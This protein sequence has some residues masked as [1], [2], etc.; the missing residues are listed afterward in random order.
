MKI[1]AEEKIERENA[2]NRLRDFLDASAHRGDQ[3]AIARMA[4]ITPAAVSKFLAGRGK[5]GAISTARA[6][7]SA[8]D[9]F[10]VVDSAQQLSRE[11][12]D[13]RE[14][15]IGKLEETIRQCRNPIVNDR[16]LGSEVYRL[17]AFLTEA[18]HEIGASLN[19][20]A[21]SALEVRHDRD[22]K[23]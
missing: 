20:D 4:G 3:G 9:A 15:L 6:I 17:A 18:T 21:E 19:Q 13:F 12:R 14:L 22:S 1:S 8:L 5:T 2:Y 7:A 16:L 10:P 11:S 23:V